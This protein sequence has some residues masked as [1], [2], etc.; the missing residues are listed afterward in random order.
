MPFTRY[1]HQC[2]LTQPIIHHP[3]SPH[4]IMLPSFLFPARGHLVFSHFCHRP[5]IPQPYCSPQT[6]YITPSPPIPTVMALLGH[7][8]T[9]FT[10]TIIILFHVP[11]TTITTNPTVSQRYQPGH[12]DLTTATKCSFSFI[13]GDSPLSATGPTYS[14]ACCKGL[15]LVAKR[16]MQCTY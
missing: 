16:S 2:F 1:H 9:S 3:V 11:S 6:P 15:C 7:P 5:C 4:L 10:T 8:I 12:H 14:Y 13:V